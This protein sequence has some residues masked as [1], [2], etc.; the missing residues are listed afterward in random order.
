MYQYIPKDKNNKTFISRISVNKFDSSYFM[1]EVDEN[2]QKVFVI[3]KKENYLNFPSQSNEYHALDS[4]F[5]SKTH[6]AILATPNEIHLQKAAKDDSKQVLRLSH[7]IQIQRI[8]SSNNE[9]EL[10]FASETAVVKFDLKTS[11]ILG[12]VSI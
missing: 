10:I 1:V 2:K 11:K 12:S 7:K 6:I 3:K 8:F 5:V 4:C 9:N